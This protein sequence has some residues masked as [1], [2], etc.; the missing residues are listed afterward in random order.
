[1]LEKF[2]RTGLFIVFLIVFLAGAG[3]L[4]KLAMP[5]IKK[6]VPSLADAIA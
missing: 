2:G 5:T 4:K 3:M 6:Y 1:V